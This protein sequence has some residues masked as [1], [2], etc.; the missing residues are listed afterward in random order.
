MQ[1][2]TSFLVM[3]F[4]Y[5]DQSQQKKPIQKRIVKAKLQFTN[6]CLSNLMFIDIFRAHKKVTL[7]EKA[8]K[9]I[10]LCCFKAVKFTVY[11]FTKIYNKKSSQLIGEV[12]QLLEGLMEV[13][14]VVVIDDMQE[15]ALNSNFSSEE[16]S[17]CCPTKY[18]L[19]TLT[20]C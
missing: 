19:H 17:F 5:A 4:Q 9:R 15:Q 18:S 2:K 10:N 13:D 3:N 1:F 20:G 11:F 8:N 14:H 16:L 7:R 6:D 12:N